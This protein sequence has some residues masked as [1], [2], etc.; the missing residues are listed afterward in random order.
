MILSDLIPIELGHLNLLQIIF[1]LELRIQILFE[2][3]KE[4]IN[5]QSSLNSKCAKIGSK[6]C[7]KA[8]SLR[9]S[10]LNLLSAIIT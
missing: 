5:Q 6:R 9:F 7:R 10:H 2:P 1:N 3:Y 4:V 8:Y